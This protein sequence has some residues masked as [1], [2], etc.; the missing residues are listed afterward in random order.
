MTNIGI[1]YNIECN[2]YITKIINQKKQM[3]SITVSKGLKNYI[4]NLI[5]ITENDK[6]GKLFEENIRKT[7]E[8]ELGWKISNIPRFFFFENC[9]ILTLQIYYFLIV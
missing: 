4:L 5:K 7:I 2:Q 1:F 6:I 8:I 9:K 3:S